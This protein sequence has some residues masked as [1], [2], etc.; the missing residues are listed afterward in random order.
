MTNF[1]LPFNLEN[2][3][4]YKKLQ[5]YSKI[6]KNWFYLSDINISF[7]YGSFSYSYWNG[8][9]NNNHGQ[10]HNYTIINDF[11]SKENIPFRIDCSN[12]L[13]TQNDLYDNHQRII[14]EI[15]NNS[16]N[17][18]DLCDFELM[19]YIKEKYQYYNFIFSQN[20][21]LINP[22]TEDIL[23]IISEQNLF[24]FIT[25][26]KRFNYNIELLT[27]LKDKRKYEIIIGDKCFNCSADQKNECIQ[28]EQ[29]YQYNFSYN[30]IYS[31]C[32]QCTYN[33]N[34][35][36]DLEQILLLKKLGFINFKIESYP[37]FLSNNFNNYLIK[38]FIKP[39]YQERFLIEK[40]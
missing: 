35:S 2:H 6:H 24:F 12:I 26:P 4:F 39:E 19:N 5:H 29:F 13:L 15:L 40:E 33:F 36:Y 22:L 20:A 8:D 11:N 17:Y 10:L 3:T 14:F 18:I 38:L 25:L 9:I 34:Y 37:S 31:K 1:S 32:E 30:S 27:Q 23:N 21:D 28:K 7:L 16:G